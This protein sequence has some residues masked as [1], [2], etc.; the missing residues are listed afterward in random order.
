MKPETLL[1][2]LV[3]FIGLYHLVIGAGLMFSQTFQHF[4]VETYGANFEW[5]VRDT[6]FI[7]IVG[8]FVFV[9]GSLA[10]AASVDPVRYALFLLCYVEFFV[11]RDIHRHLYSAELYEG[12]HVSPAINVLTSVVFAVQAVAL[13]WLL[14]RCKRAPQADP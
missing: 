2:A 3:F 7:R 12:F 4:A 11:L 6:Y 1:K 10:L 8:S 14:W 5:T 13:G 9:L